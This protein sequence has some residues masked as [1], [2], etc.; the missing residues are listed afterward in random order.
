MADRLSLISTTLLIEMYLGIIVVGEVFKL[1]IK[2]NMA[3][4][5]SQLEIY[6]IIL[7]RK[8]V[9]QIIKEKEGIERGVNDTILF[10]SLYSRILT[11]LTQ[12]AAW[13]SDRT[14]VGLSLLSNEG[15][16]VN[17][18][19]TAYSIQN[20]IEG[21]IDGGQ[22]DKIRVAAE[23]NNVSEK[24]IL[25]R[26][27]MIASRF[28]LY[29]HLPLDSKIGLLFL[30]RKTGQNIKSAIEFLLSDILRTNH[31]IKLERYVPQSLIDDFKNNG[32]I[33]NF[34]FT[35]FI[36]TSVNDG[37]D[38]EQVER[39]YNVTIKITPT[40][41]NKPGYN[42]IHQ[43][44]DFIGQSN[45]KIGNTLKSLSN[46]GKKKGSLKKEDKAYSSAISDDLKIKP[47]ISIDDELQDEEMG[48]LK[49]T[50]IKSMCDI[51]LEQIRNDV[52]IIQ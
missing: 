37:N 7:G 9:R 49:R 11:E 3:K 10:N 25:G 31:N 43:A 39:G 32:I 20:L 46:F 41:G 47:I 29:L 2:K 34:T 51:L 48:I 26:N 35:D 13:H 18:I 14:K 17:Q 8:T 23:M 36:T 38:I 22:Y 6:K 52:Y 24:T 19:L 44:L 45:F 28:Y 42:F 30:E 40:N 50:D 27:K 21:Y 5:E 4:T 15:E 1:N 12:D 33:D 16:D